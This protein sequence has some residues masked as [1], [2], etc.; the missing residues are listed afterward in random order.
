MNNEKIPPDTDTVPGG[1]HAKRDRP[2]SRRSAGC[3]FIDSL[4][5]TA[6][7]NGRSENTQH[8][9]GETPN[10]FVSRRVFFWC[11]GHTN[12]PAETIEM[13]T[14]SH[15]ERKELTEQGDVHGSPRTGDE[16]TARGA[17]RSGA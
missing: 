9:Q 3:E 17:I 4:Q 11:D 15:S 7:K 2:R 14:Q 13:R 1:S 6:N 16:R 12:A 10:A 5:E 8:E